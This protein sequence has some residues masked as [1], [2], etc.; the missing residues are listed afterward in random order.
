MKFDRAVLRVELRPWLHH[1][2]SNNTE[3]LHYGSL[4]NIKIGVWFNGIKLD[5]YL[6]KGDEL[7][8][9]IIINE[10]YPRHE[11]LRFYTVPLEKIISGEN[12]VVIR[13]IDRETVSCE[14]NSL[15]IALYR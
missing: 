15:E 10:A 2:S 13:N 6:H 11:T 12:E 8:K 7:F 9:P 4:K 14:F 1:E 3:S 5:S